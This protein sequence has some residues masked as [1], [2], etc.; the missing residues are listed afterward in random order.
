MVGLVIGISAPSQITMD[1]IYCL[2]RIKTLDH[3]LMSHNKKEAIPKASTKG[4]ISRLN[5]ITIFSQIMPKTWFTESNNYMHLYKDDQTIGKTKHVFIILYASGVL[6]R[7]SIN[8]NIE[9]EFK[10]QLY[11]PL[12]FCLILRFT[13]SLRDILCHHAPFGPH[14][15]S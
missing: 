5:N 10:R 14:H 6:F 4:P 1:I 13:Q 2:K 9:C 8:L 11:A 15:K 3:S 12:T 7:K